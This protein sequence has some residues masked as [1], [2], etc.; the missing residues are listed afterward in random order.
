MSASHQGYAPYRSGPGGCALRAGGLRCASARAAHGCAG[1]RASKR[2]GL[3]WGGRRREAV[4]EP[5]VRHAAWARPALLSTPPTCGPCEL[6][7]TPLLPLHCCR[8][9]LLL[10]CGARA[11]AHAVPLSA[12]RGAR[13]ASSPLPLPPS[14]TV[15][16]T[17][18]F[19]VPL[20]V[21]ALTVRLRQAVNAAH[22]RTQ[23][24]AAGSFRLLEWRH[25][26]LRGAS[27]LLPLLW[28]RLFLS[29]SCPSWCNS[30]ASGPLQQRAKKVQSM[31][32]RREDV[33]KAG[34]RVWPHA[35]QRREVLWAPWGVSSRAGS[36]ETRTRCNCMR[37]DGGSQQ[38][39]QRQ[40]RAH[41][42]LVLRHAQ[43]T[44]ERAWIQTERSQTEA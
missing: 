15:Q 27:C 40:R 17:V 33:V 41:L 25:D 37:A 35:R 39:Q 42:V 43:V 38:Q 8:V 5:G 4:S 28:D 13:A 23:L 30:Q 16:R 22:H 19:K 36:S 2:G 7:V 34:L 44:K 24:A 12:C 1:K 3:V 11:V 21:A 26:A 32:G 29:L 20:K 9:L 31:V 18:P 6:C 14:T 10:C